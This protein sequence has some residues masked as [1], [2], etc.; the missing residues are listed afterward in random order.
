MLQQIETKLREVAD[1]VFYGSADDIAGNVLW[2]YIVF[3][4]DRATRTSTNNSFTDYYSV[5]IVHE[6]WVP[7]EMISDV[8]E[9]LESLPG[10][11]LANS[12]IGFNYTFKPNTSAVIE[13]A[14]LTFSRARKRVQ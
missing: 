12:D 9:K 4:R 7:D 2:K 8:I 6:N 13:I 3:W 10:V 1:L 11:R 14:T 5:S